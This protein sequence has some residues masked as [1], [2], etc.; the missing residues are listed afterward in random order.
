M[1]ISTGKLWL[2]ATTLVIGAAH[3]RKSITE[4]GA[5]MDTITFSDD[6]GQPAIIE[7][8]ERGNTNKTFRWRAQDRFV[9]EIILQCSDPNP[10][11]TPEIIARG[12]FGEDPATATVE[13][14]LLFTPRNSVTSRLRTGTSTK[15][16][17]RGSTT[18]SKA[19]RL[20]QGAVIGIAVGAGILGLIIIFAFVWLVVRRQRRK[21]QLLHIDSYKSGNH[22]TD[23]LI[24]EKEAHAGVDVTIPQ[25]PYSDD[26]NGPTA[27]A[28]T[29]AT[30]VS[31]T[32]LHH[33]PQ[34][35]DPNQTFTPY[36]DRSSAALRQADDGRASVVPSPIPGRG[37]PRDLTTPYAHL[38][39][40][41][42]TED[43]VR[44]LE[45]EERQLDAAIEQARRR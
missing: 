2:A 1:R 6:F 4:P 10:P 9:E 34:Q 22:H 32:H 24:A 13:T 44:R 19:G 33:Q 37:T 41:G 29:S 38:V 17:A 14:L 23:D 5:A 11:G 43:D 26:G 12:R 45:E 3:G 16:P 8:G 15:I 39:E 7:L 36:T 42:M 28:S 20:P 21:Q 31:S 18:D 30:A 40:E 25:S 35:Q 27:P